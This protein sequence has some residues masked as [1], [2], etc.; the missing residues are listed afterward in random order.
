MLRLSTGEGCGLLAEKSVLCCVV[1]WHIILAGLR[2]LA[3]PDP[4]IVGL[5]L[6]LEE[7]VEHDI[8]QEKASGLE[9]PGRVVNTRGC[10]RSNPHTEASNEPSLDKN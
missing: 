7:R 9:I 6:S 2:R 3:L 1:E 5:V 8:S 10:D 4:V